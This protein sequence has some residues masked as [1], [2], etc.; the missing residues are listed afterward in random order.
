MVPLLLFKEKILWEGNYERHYKRRSV[1]EHLD[2]RT[3]VCTN[4]HAISQYIASKR[5]EDIEKHHMLR[6]LL[7]IR[8]EVPKDNIIAQAGKDDFLRRFDEL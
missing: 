2:K 8:D 5:E 7:H 6:F 4:L 3:L 1:N